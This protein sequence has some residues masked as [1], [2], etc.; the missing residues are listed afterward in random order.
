MEQK[1]IAKSV[2]SRK[3]TARKL[4]RETS[5]HSVHLFSTRTQYR[6]CPKNTKN[7]IENVHMTGP[8]GL[9]AAGI[10]Y[11]INI[12][13]VSPKSGFCFL[14]FSRKFLY[15]VAGQQQGCGSAPFSRALFGFCRDGR[16]LG[17]DIL[18]D[19]RQY[20]KWEIKE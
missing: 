15:K 20:G 11:F 18:K 17:Q 5:T 6:F 3:F 19:H 13:R 9:G 1:R 7:C 8:N 4:I 12:G 14:A 16:S 10:S 2:F